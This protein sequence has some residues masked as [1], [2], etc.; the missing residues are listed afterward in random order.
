MGVLCE[1]GNTAVYSPHYYS[2]ARL[3][4]S[5]IGAIV[6]ALLGIPHSPDHKFEVLRKSP[7][8][9]EQ[10]SQ[11]TAHST[12]QQQPSQLSLNPKP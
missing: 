8:K 7:S 10:V 11:A 2:E 6:G 1:V 5:R 12:T 9:S 4:S 3:G